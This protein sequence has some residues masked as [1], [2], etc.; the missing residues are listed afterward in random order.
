MINLHI[1]PIGSRPGIW[2]GLGKIHEE[3]WI[4]LP[5]FH[6]ILSTIGIPTYKLA[7]FLLQFLIP[8]TSVEYTAFGSFTFP[9][10]ICHKRTPTYTWLV[11]TLI[12]YLHIFP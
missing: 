10:E 7:K 5:F 2:Y 8:S 12:L 11:L 6:A 3:T 4:G 9:E 1:K